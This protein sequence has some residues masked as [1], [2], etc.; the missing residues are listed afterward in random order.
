[1]P[2]TEAQIERYSRHII[3]DKVGGVGQEKLLSAK[4]LIVGTGGLGAPAALY[5]AAAGVGTIGLLDGD[6]VDLTNLQRQIIH[7][8]EDVGVR[9]VDSALAKMHAINPNVTIRTYDVWARADNLAQIVREYDFVIDG[10]DNFAAKFLI[11][12]V[13]YFEQIPFSHAGIL[14]FEGQ[15]MTVLPNATACYR[16]VFPA[17]PPAGSV[18]SCGQAGVLGVLPGVVGSLQATEAIKHLLGI[19][20]LLTDTLLT[21]NALTM[22][23]RKI[24]VGR[25]P[26]CPL[27]GRNPE[28]TEVRD[29]KQVVCEQRGCVC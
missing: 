14:Q 5:L 7:H 4:V 2:L 15:L 26:E 21:Y 27:C 20:E 23:F 10:V 11:N 12:D 25:N 3:L 24:P 29:E 18:P 6:A 19:G 1:M 17:P 22:T 9:K 16:C 8:T 13:C 28:I